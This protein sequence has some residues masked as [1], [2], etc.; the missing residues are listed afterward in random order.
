M[1]A[2]ILLVEDEQEL[3]TTLGIRLR[4]EGYTV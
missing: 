4:V 2:T 1:N 3:S